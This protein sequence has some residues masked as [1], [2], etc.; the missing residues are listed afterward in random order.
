MAHSFERRK[1]GTLTARLEQYEVTLLRG[2]VGDVVGLVR[3]EPAGNA[4]YARLFPDPSFDREAAAELHGLIH[5]DLRETKL[6][7]AQALLDTL[8]DDGD[9][10]LDVA[11]AEQWLTALN[12]VRLALGTAI[13]ITEETYDREPAEEDMALRVYDWVTILQE[14]LV[15]AVSAGGV[16]R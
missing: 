11:S 7:A 3:T 8:P 6:A 16:D 2:L 15:Q 4:S 5:D 13:G 1:D 9:V 14:T 10:T 12:D